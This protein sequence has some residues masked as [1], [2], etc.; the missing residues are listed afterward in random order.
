[1]S[2]MKHELP[3]AEDGFIVPK[4]YMHGRFEH[5]EIQESINDETALVGFA[6]G[7]VLKYVSANRQGENRLRAFKKANYYLTEI[8]NV[9]SEKEK[10]DEKHI[11]PQ[12]YTSQEIQPID[13]IEDQFP[14]D[15]VIGHHKCQVIRYITRCFYKGHLLDDLVKAKYYLDRAIKILENEEQENK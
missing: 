8:I 5:M 7:M 9:L 11:K 12:Y 14:L 3:K 13:I 6:C 2:K 4:H 10:V 15:A 1:M